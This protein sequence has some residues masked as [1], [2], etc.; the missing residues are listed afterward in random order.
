MDSDEKSG[1]EEE[2][3]GRGQGSSRPKRKTRSEVV[4][5]AESSLSASAHKRRLTGP[6]PSV[7]SSK[8]RSRKGE[9]PAS[10]P[11]Q[12]GPGSTSTRPV[13][14]LLGKVSTTLCLSK[15]PKSGPA[16]YR[17][18][19]LMES[20][21]LTEARAIVVAELK[22]VWLHHFGRRL[23]LGKDLGSD[24]NGPEEESLKIIKS[25]RKI[26]DKLVELHQRWRNLEKESRRPARAAGRAFM[27]K[28]VR[29][30][31]ELEL[32]FDI[33]KKEAGLVLERS[34]NIDWREDVEYLR[35]QMTKEQPGCPGSWDSRQK[36]KDERKLR[37]KQREEARI[38]KEKKGE[39]ELAEQKSEF[40]KENIE[41]ISVDENENEMEIKQTRSRGSFDV[42][43]A[44]A[45][46]CDRLN[47]SV[48]DTAMVA[49]SVVNACGI[50]I[51]KTNINRGSA[52]KRRQQARL[53]KAGEIKESFEC[54][55]NCVIHW[56]GKMLHLRG[57]VGSNRVCVYLSGI[58]ENQTKKLLG[59]PEAETGRGIAEFE[60]VKGCMSEWQVKEEV[61]GMVFDTT[62]ANT[63]EHSGACR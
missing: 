40:E 29:L 11:Y 38:E 33:R 58:D 56:D 27:E 57:R 61:V 18:L 28:Q 25:D 62:A 50:D 6:T 51:S 46:T 9:A 21:S 17:L 32:P 5:L 42:M 34:G 12:L 55:E 24:D 1:N 31:L 47:L 13:F 7:S 3:T 26:G 44:I 2:T 19:F 35:S 8:V 45:Q 60:V 41:E 52:W 59:I 49:A 22:E 14:F 48:R 43:G 16:L 23:V 37:E 63:G 39:A 54:P 53:K 10:S 20:K 4:S 15:L 30:G 36:K